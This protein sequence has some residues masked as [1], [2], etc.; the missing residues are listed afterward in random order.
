MFIIFVRYHD[1][2]LFKTLN[3]IKTINLNSCI[4]R[5]FELSYPDFV[6]Q[7]RNYMLVITHISQFTVD[8]IINLYFLNLN[9][10]RNIT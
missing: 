1:V 7:F 5:H 6:N 10:L 2:F 8:D 9:M 4:E 3:Y